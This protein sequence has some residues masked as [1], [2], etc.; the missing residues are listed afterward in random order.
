MR[1]SH[2]LDWAP[3]LLPVYLLSS[4]TPSALGRHLP[5]PGCLRTRAPAKSMVSQP[6]G[7]GGGGP[8]QT[9][10]AGRRKRGKWPGKETEEAWPQMCNSHVGRTELL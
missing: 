7:K 8:G 3:S 9:G 6:Q 10:Q 5:R 4:D 1:P 2:G